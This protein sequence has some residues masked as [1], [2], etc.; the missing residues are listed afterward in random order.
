MQDLIHFLIKIYSPLSIVDLVEAETRLIS[1]QDYIKTSKDLLSTVN[2]FSFK[3]TKVYQNHTCI[4]GT[5]VNI[6]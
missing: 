6:N 2:N 4:R 5:Q 3:C 1:F